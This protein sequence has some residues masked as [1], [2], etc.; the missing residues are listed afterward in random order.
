METYQL[1][2]RLSFPQHHRLI[3]YSYLDLK[4][5]LEKISILSKRERQE[6]R[7]SVIARE[8]KTFRFKAKHDGQCLLHGDR[9]AVFM[10]KMSIDLCQNIDL[11]RNE[12]KREVSR[13]DEHKF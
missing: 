12:Y 10:G 9:L 7:N 8:G 1:E 11:G 2:G 6:L 5:T 13:C 4:T 3:I